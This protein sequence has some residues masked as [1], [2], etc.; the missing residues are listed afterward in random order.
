MADATDSKSVVRK[1]VWVQVPPP[2]LENKYFFVLGRLAAPE[3]KVPNPNQTQTR[4]VRESDCHGD[5]TQNRIQ[6]GRRSHR[7]ASLYGIRSDLI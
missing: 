3:D 1:D 4:G 5:G 2:V 6:K 7:V